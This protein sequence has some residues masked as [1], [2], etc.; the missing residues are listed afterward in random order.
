MSH[1]EL[2]HTMGTIVTLDV[3]GDVPPERLLPALAAAA[4]DLR[5]VDELLSTWRPASWAS[6]LLAGTAAPSAAPAPVRE[7]LALAA[8][9]ETAT[10]GWFSPG[11][12]GAAGPDATGLV[13]GWAAQRASDRL[14]A[15]GLRDHVV[16]AAGDLVVA[17]LPAPEAPDQPWRVGISDPVDPG[18][19]LGHVELTTTAGRWAVAT[20][21]PAEQGQH[22]V[23][24]RTGT[25]VAGVASAS[26]LVREEPS[27]PQ[28]GAW[29]D[30]CATALV[31]ADRDAG[32]L[33]DRLCALGVPGFVL[34]ARGRLTDPGG[35][36][37][38]S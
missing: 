18:A 11:W 27:R 13:K 20:S 16:N 26:V 25:L 4:V 32:L 15:H 38:R 28:A 22:V 29:A 5:Q 2:V 6:R 24:P 14:L 31:A 21:G 19:L 36:L 33:L 17:G 35:L 37:R 3:R 7:V 1:V 34:D 30:A 12:R 8:D 9:L 10:D 23:D